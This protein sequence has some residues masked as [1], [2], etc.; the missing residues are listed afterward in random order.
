MSRALTRVADME[1]TVR[2]HLSEA[3]KRRRKKENNI[4]NRARGS[5]EARRHIK[6]GMLSLKVIQRARSAHGGTAPR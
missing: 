6:F 5:N 4:S 1:F 2:A 3:V